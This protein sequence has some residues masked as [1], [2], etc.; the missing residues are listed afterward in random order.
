MQRPAARAP[1]ARRG[2]VG[3]LVRVSKCSAFLLLSTLSACDRRTPEGEEAEK[4]A[5]A[6]KAAPVKVPPSYTFPS[7]RIERVRP[8]SPGSSKL[9][10]L[11]I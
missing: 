7:G 5:D 8:R 11:G 9:L 4:R 2:L 1:G 6:L 10:F 3:R